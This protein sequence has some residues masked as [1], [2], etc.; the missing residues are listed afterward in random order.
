MEFKTWSCIVRKTVQTCRYEKEITVA[1]PA[2]I[3][4]TLGPNQGWRWG[5]DTEVAQLGL[6][7]PKQAA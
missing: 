1:R 6:K 7:P 4:G 5:M 2:D 3:E